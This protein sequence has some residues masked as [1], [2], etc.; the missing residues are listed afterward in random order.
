MIWISIVCGALVVFPMSTA[1]G[2]GAGSKGSDVLDLQIMLSTLDEF[3]GTITGYYGTQTVSAVTQFQRR[4]SLPIT[5]V[6]DDQT[7][8]S[9]VW[10]YSQLKAPPGKATPM[11]TGNRTP[12]PP[13]KPTPA[14]TSMITPVPNAYPLTELS[15][16][17]G[18]MIQLVNQARVQ[19][20]LPAL[21]ADSALTQTARLKSQDMV[22]LNYFAH[23]SP[24]YGSP[25]DMMGRFGITFQ[26]AGENIA[27]NQTVIA[28]HQALMNSQGHRDNILNNSFTSIGIGIVDGGPCGQMYTQQFVGR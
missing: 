14:S 6:V 3:N 25:F 17:E 9:I 10:A 18:Q 27:C 28:A 19:S 5:G 8:R 15:A 24:T 20:G 7:L 12:T 22:N 16:V 13:L 21:T 1:W 26:S 23:Q 11:P 4:Y 2:F